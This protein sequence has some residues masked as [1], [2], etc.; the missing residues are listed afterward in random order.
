MEFRRLNRTNHLKVL[1]PR[2]TVLCTSKLEEKA[3]IITLA[4]TMIVSRNPPIVAISVAPLRFSHNL[5][6]NSGEFT[7]NV[8]TREIIS[9]V[10]YCGSHSGRNQ[11][12]FKSTKLTLLDGI[13][14]KCPRIQ[15]CIAHIECKVIDSK[16]YGDHTLFIGEVVTCFGRD[17]ILSG[18]ET[19][20]E[21]IEIPYHLGG[22]KFVFNKKEVFRV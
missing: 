13:N 20:L 12:K 5:I 4:W 7:I 16:K 1:H 17:D 9:E 10:H 18:N 19:D 3:N 8:P 15:E 21:K 22:K 11:D 14:V 6:K 2:Q